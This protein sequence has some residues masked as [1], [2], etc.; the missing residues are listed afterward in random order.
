VTARAAFLNGFVGRPWAKD[1]L[2][3]WAFVGEVERVLFGRALPLFPVMPELRQVVRLF[4][5]HPERRNWR[6]IPAPVDG[7]IVMASRIAAAERAE[8]H[9]GV[10]LVT[11]GPGR[12][13]HCDEPQG[14]EHVS[15]V[16]LIELRR[17]SLRYFEP[18]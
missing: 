17:W 11:D 7:A 2:H 8:I 5:S 4:R 18:V 13:W 12:V 6:E 14:V 3:C 1:G 10:F 15:P 16:E 9:C